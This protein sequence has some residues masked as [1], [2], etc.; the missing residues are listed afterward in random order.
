MVAT[1]TL[2][3]IPYAQSFDPFCD[4]AA[5]TQAMA[6]RVDELLDT[7]FAALGLLE[8]PQYAS[9]SITTPAPTED[10]RI[11]FDTTDEDTANL[12]DLALDPFSIYPDSTGIWYTGVHGASITIVGATETWSTGTFLVNMFVNQSQTIR[13]E[14]AFRS[15]GSLAT[16]AVYDTSDNYRLDTTFFASGVTLVA[17]VYK[18]RF[19]AWRYS[20]LP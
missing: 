4:G 19:W 17:D 18:A 2:W 9:I 14:G 20:D 10:Y 3:S 5:I 15:V 7:Q 16:T 13:E 11:R 8:R 6:E 1:T 12:V